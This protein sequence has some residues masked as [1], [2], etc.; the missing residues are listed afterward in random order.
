MYILIALLFVNAI[1]VSIKRK[2][3]IKDCDGN[4][5]VCTCGRKDNEDK[6]DK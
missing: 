5:D 1:R 2:S 4:C 6:C 3:F